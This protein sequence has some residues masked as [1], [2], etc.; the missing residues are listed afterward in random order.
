[1]ITVNTLLND[2]FL[3]STGFWYKDAVLYP[4]SRTHIRG[5]LDF[6]ELFSRDKSFLLDTY[7]KYSEKIGFEGRARGE[8][9]TTLVD[10]GWIR[11]RLYEKPNRY[12]RIQ[13]K[14]PEQ[15]N[16]EIQEFLDYAH[17]HIGLQEDD[18]VRV[19]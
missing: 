4:I 14:N 3:L 19:G 13:C 8:I 11:I 7:R 9:I 2:G 1:M 18:D 17:R 12:L 6:P 15:Q 16:T 10:E 5:V